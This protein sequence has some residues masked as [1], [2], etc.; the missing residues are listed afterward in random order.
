MKSK[1]ID[2]LKRLAGNGVFPY[3]FAWML[4][5]SLRSLVLSPKRLV[6]W[7]ELNETA[8]GYFPFPNKPGIRII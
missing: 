7:L 4:L 3:Q 5:N 6:K 8:V 2:V 1:Y